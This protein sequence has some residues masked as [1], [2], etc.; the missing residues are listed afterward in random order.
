MRLQAKRSP[1]SP[2]SNTPL[3]GIIDTRGYQ[4]KQPGMSMTPKR[5]D[6]HCHSQASNR[7]AEVVLNAI[8][9]PE[10]YSDPLE[11]FAQAKRRGMDFVTI[12][13]HDTIAGAVALRQTRPGEVVVGEE[14]TCWFPE[15]ACKLHLLVYGIDDHQ[16]DELQRRAKNVYAVA[17]FVE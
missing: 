17:E 4:I 10:C 15:D 11:V 6:L 1:K 5:I 16:H 8:R 13:D 2:F 7:A 12:T 14:V 3:P 9:C